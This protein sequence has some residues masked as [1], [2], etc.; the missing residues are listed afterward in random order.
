MN[1]ST[2]NFLDEAFLNL[3]F[4]KAKTELRNR[5]KPLPSEEHR[6]MPA[7]KHGLLGDPPVLPNT[8]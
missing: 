3:C 4:I 2:S 6:Q 7:D 5:C 1:P 8:F